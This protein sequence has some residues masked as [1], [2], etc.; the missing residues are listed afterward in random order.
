MSNRLHLSDFLRR[1]NFH[2]HELAHCM[3]GS[4]NGDIYL[5][6]G[7]RAK[8]G[9]VYVKDGSG[10]P[11]ELEIWQIEVCSTSAASIENRIE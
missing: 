7:N 9:M 8:P 3:T 4:M 11:F 1:P 6:D 2:V 10:R 5:Q